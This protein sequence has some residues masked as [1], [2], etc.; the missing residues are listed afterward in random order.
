MPEALP[1]IRMVQSAI[2]STDNQGVGMI[3]G[4]YTDYIMKD[5]FA[6]YS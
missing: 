3:K 4:V 1:C 5:L 2:H 6:S